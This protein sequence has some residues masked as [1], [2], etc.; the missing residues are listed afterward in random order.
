M[1]TSRKI[2]SLCIMLAFMA[3]QAQAFPG[4]TAPSQQ[5]AQAAPAAG[6]TKGT[7]VETMDAGGYTYVQLENDGQKH[8]VAI[9]ESQVKVGDEVELVAGMEMRNFKSKSLDRTFDTIIFSQGLMK[10]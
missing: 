2:L 1:S 8:W 7:V 5:P 4:A 10:R 9:P 3:V 6:F